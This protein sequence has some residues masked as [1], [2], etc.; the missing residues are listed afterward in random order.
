MRCS[1]FSDGDLIQNTRP[2]RFYRFTDPKYGRV[3][4]W[5]IFRNTNFYGDKMPVGTV[6]RVVGTVRDIYT[7]LEII[8]SAHPDVGP[9]RR[10]AAIVVSKWDWEKAEIS[11]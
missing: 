8:E 5:D 11:A 1:D 4:L 3:Q 10:V 6:V 7:E 2:V 9:G